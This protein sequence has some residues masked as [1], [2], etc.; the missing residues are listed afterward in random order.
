MKIE[1]LR[2]LG[3]FAC[4]CAQVEVGI[5]GSTLSRRVSVYFNLRIHHSSH[6]QTPSR[7]HLL[8]QDY[9]STRGPSRCALGKISSKGM[10]L[11]CS[12]AFKQK[13]KLCRAICSGESPRLRA[14]LRPCSSSSSQS[15]RQ[16]RENENVSAAAAA[17][18]LTAQSFA[19]L[20]VRQQND[21]SERYVRRDVL[22]LF[23]SASAERSFG[24]PEASRRS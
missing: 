6:L 22:W 10:S 12:A 17:A 7:G 24:D 14:V 20:P 16:G 8:P 23:S 21:L 4:Q 19:L 2:M 5:K 11:S 9:Q 1:M 13:A 18:R 15:A 3:S